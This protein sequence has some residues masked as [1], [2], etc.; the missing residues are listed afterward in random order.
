MLPLCVGVVLCLC[1]VQSC[2]RNQ[3]IGFTQLALRTPVFWDAD[4]ITRPLFGL[5][6]ASPQA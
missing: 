5:R 3:P 2:S 6:E 1:P 4:E